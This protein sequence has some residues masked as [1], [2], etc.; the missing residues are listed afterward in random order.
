MARGPLRK[1]CFHRLDLSVSLFPENSRPDFQFK[2]LAGELS[3]RR[4]SLFSFCIE[5][6]KNF[7][8]EDTRSHT[9]PKAILD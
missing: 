5:F 7:I 8:H 4:L 3:M 9:K 2:T 1:N 6:K